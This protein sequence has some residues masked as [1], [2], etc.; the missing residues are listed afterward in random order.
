MPTNKEIREK[1]HSEMKN[2]SVAD[3]KKMSESIKN[4]YG[5]RTLSKLTKTELMSILPK[6][7]NEHDMSASGLVGGKHR[8]HASGLVGGKHRVYASGLS[9]G[10]SHDR[11]M[12]S[13]LVRRVVRRVPGTIDDGSGLS[14]GRHRKTHMCG[15]GCMDCT[16]RGGVGAAA[17][18][19]SVVKPLSDLSSGIIGAVQTNKKEREIYSKR[20]SNDKLKLFKKYQKQFPSWSE[21]KILQY[22]DSQY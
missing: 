21:D 8:M 22:I 7:E 14:G 19:A 5:G 1:I 13:D 9:G 16:M 3:R 15:S 11:G 10:E 6:F 17:L 2:H 4:K 12:M 20:K 18:A